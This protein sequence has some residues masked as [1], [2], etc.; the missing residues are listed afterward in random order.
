M[1]FSKHVLIVA[2]VAILMIA[3][4]VGFQA[5]R[6]APYAPGDGDVALL[7]PNLKYQELSSK[8]TD[9]L[10]PRDKK[11][12]ARVLELARLKKRWLEVKDQAKLTPELQAL[13]MEST[14]SLLCPRELLSLLEYLDGNDMANFAGAIRRRVPAL[15]DSDHGPEA[16]KLL[17]DLTHRP[18]DGDITIMPMLGGWSYHAALSV[19]DEEKFEAFRNSLGNQMFIMTASFGWNV[20]LAKSDP[21]EAITSTLNLLASGESTYLGDYLLPI[22]I[23]NIPEETNLAEIESLL[24]PLNSEMNSREIEKG[25]SRLL[26]KWT[27]F[28]PAAAANF[29]IGNPERADPSEITGITMAVIRN[30]WESGLEWVEHFP[31]GPY[32]DAAARAAI[33]QIYR[34]RPE[35]AQRYAAM[36]ENEALRE[37]SMTEIQK[38][39][40][41]R[42]LSLPMEGQ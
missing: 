38:V 18:A 13:A 23:S 26:L 33:A 5:S 14:V 16:R 9:R 8:V 27:Q 19:D 28:D 40:D 29:V 17:A 35:E 42:G 36:I 7:D 39:I 32:L 34:S 6:Q 37:Q 41:D 12:A 15:F 24:P 20:Q 3:V 11:A 25:R 1:K 31:P 2:A 10:F 21:V 30:K 22:V 4:I